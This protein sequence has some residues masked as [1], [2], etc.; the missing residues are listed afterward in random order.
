MTDLTEQLAAVI[1]EAVRTELKYD[2]ANKEMYL[3]DAAFP[4]RGP[5]SVKSSAHLRPS[6][7]RTSDSGGGFTLH[8]RWTWGSTAVDLYALPQEEGK[9]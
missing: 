5:S 8:G 6:H 4:R 3:R 2:G 1:A 9:L 7:N